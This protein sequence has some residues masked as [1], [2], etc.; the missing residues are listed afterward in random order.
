MLSAASSVGVS[1]GSSLPCLFY[2][3]NSTESL[4]KAGLKLTPYHRKQAF[5]LQENCKRFIS[6]FGIDYVGFLTLTFAD[7]CTDHKEAQRRFNS[8]SSHFLR[9]TF[10]QYVLV[11][12]RQIRGAWHYHLLVG[13]PENI[14]TGFNFD[15]VFP[16]KGRGKYISASPYL[17]SLWKE[18]RDAMKRYGFGRSELAPIKSNEG[19]IADYVGKYIAA[20][21]EGRHRAGYEEEDKGIRIVS[22]SQKWNRSNSNFA[23]NT[24][25]GKEWRRKAKRFTVEYLHLKEYDDLSRLLGSRWSYWCGDYINDIDRILDDRQAH[26]D[27]KAAIEDLSNNVILNKD[28]GEILST[29]PRLHQ[30]DTPFFPWWFRGG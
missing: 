25:G 24:P 2:S 18:L 19:V 17:R 8:L 26:E 9:K 3:N 27:M 12:E 22:Y 10:L 15:E 5:V 28:T 6:M 16:K 29:P 13:L 7:N 1:V 23:W 30:A 14:R 4:P 11:K 20:N 21:A